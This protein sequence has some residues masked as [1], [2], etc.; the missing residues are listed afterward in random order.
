MTTQMADDVTPA[1]F[2]RLERH[3]ILLGLGAAQLT[4]LAMALL[5]AVVSVY[6]A[7]AAGFAT[8]A[9]VWLPAAAAATAT[10][11]GRPVVAWVPLI[12]QW[13]VRRLLGQ[14]SH[15]TRATLPAPATLQ[16]P[17]IP[18]VLRVSEAPGLGAALVHDRRRGTVSAI[19]RVSGTGFVLD[20]DAVQEHKVSSWGRVLGSLSQQPS[21]VRLQLMVRTVPGGA[22]T[23]RRWWRA[24]ALAGASWAAQILADLVEESY[25][26]D[27]RQEALVA[28][29]LR[30][31]RGS[32]RGLT[33]G[34]IA[35]LAQDLSALRDSLRGADLRVDEWVP[36]GQLGSVLRTAYDPEGTKRGQDH[37]DAPSPLLAPMGVQEHWSC[38]RTDGAVHAT[39]WVT[40]WPRA[41]V[42]PSFLQPLLLAPD[43]YRTITLLAEPL[44]TGKALREIRRAK[45]EHVSDAAQ[46]ARIGQIEDES[47]RAEVEELNRREQELV[48]GHGDLRFTGLV[49]VTAPTE[50]ALNGAC[51]A[52]ESAAAQ[53]MCEIRRLVGQ[54]GLAHLAAALPLA[55]GVL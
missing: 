9:L 44:P 18:G 40:E 16:L 7:G 26:F 30:V 21:V 1:R 28:V 11:R 13:R 31:P 14:T 45:V 5:V 33:D 15:T 3:G 20:D 19:A 4:V 22:S 48:A 38:L 10:V 27:H 43:A 54:Q 34:G 35:R 23:T 6:A 39:Y 50:D 29:A 42:H 24:N 47:T 51:A 46:R 17:G 52:T 37:G 36:P 8:S 53:S 41:E 32:G 2:G 12:L 55:R 25:A 49:T